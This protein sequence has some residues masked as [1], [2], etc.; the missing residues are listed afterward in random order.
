MRCVCE[1]EGAGKSTTRLPSPDPH[2][3]SVAA[4]RR[5]PRAV[6]LLPSGISEV[7]F[8]YR[9]GAAGAPLAV[10]SR[11][12]RRRGA[13]PPL[14]VSP[15]PLPPHS[16]HPRLRLSEAGAGVS[17]VGGRARPAAGPSF[18]PCPR[19]P[20]TPPLSGYLAIAF[21]RVGLKTPGGGRPAVP[22]VGGAAGPVG[23]VARRRGAAAPAWRVAALPRTPVPSA[24]PRR[25]RGPGAP[26]SRAPVGLVPRASLAPIGGAAVG[27]VA[28]RGVPSPTVFAL[29]TP[30]LSR[31][32]SRR[33]A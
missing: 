7:L 19:P 29:P 12:G 26:P 3:A 10:L 23:R 33:P 24:A 1:V 14:R 22:G 15:P 5:S 9:G 32:L 28:G 4:H 18:P 2:P 31:F 20:A 17:C 13:P 30:V 16:L 11:W 8:V 21:R 27:R 6:P 25:G